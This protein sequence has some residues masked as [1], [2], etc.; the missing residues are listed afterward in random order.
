MST[1][2]EQAAG[3][4]AVLN[5]VADVGVVMEKQPNP[6][7][8]TFAKFIATFSFTPQG[9]SKQ[10]RAWTIQYVGET[11]VNP[12]MALGASKTMRHTRWVIRGHMSWNDSGD[13][14]TVFRDLVEAVTTALDAARSLNGTARDHDPCQVDL[15][16]NGSGVVLGDVLCH[17]AEI[18]L[19][20]KVEQT[21][22][23]H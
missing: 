6:A 15:P 4:A 14:E 20:A 17:Y 8:P 1:L 5:T 11:R 22:A 2:N 12:T 16:A 19:T 9:G 18:T 21:L 13:S 7:P 3:I 10:V 23:T